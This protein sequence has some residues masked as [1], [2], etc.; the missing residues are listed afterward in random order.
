MANTC[1]SDT[2]IIESFLLPRPLLSQVTFQITF[3]D[4][5]AKL[6]FNYCAPATFCYGN[7]TLHN[8]IKCFFPLRVILWFLMVQSK[9]QTLIIAMEMEE[10]Q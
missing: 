5:L 3:E 4:N 8:H 10:L 7:N 2:K 1:A 9:K 6:L